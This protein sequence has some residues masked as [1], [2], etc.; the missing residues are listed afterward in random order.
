MRAGKGTTHAIHPMHASWSPLEG[1]DAIPYFFP[2]KS[3]EHWGEGA[4][5]LQV[6]LVVFSL[7]LHISLVC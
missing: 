1:H 7:V 3:C 5:R 6:A 2:W 4:G